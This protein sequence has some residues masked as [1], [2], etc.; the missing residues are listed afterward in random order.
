MT[1][2]KPHKNRNLAYFIAIL[3]TLIIGGGVL[4]IFEYNGVADARFDVVALKRQVQDLEVKNADLKN[5]LFSYT[6]PQKL[7]AAATNFNLT[8][9]KKPQYLNQQQ[10]LSASTR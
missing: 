8:L 4:Y 2:I 3:F 1:I 6:D 5:S 10:W 9:D 7:E